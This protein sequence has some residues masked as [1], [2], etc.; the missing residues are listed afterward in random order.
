MAH[1]TANEFAAKHAGLHP[2]RC[3]PRPATTSSTTELLSAASD[4]SAASCV[5][6]DETPRMR[7][8]VSSV[9]ANAAAE[10]RSAPHTRELL[11]LYKRGRGKG[12]NGAYRPSNISIQTT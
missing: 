10:A 2:N 5:T 11:T 1:E 7:A 3:V 6:A 9:I 4:R 8:C 12:G